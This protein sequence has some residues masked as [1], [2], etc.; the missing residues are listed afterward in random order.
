[1][2]RGIGG[3]TTKA[4]EVII[5]AVEFPEVR[6]GTVGTWVVSEILE[7]SSDL[8]SGVGEFCWCT[9]LLFNKVKEVTGSIFQVQDSL[10]GL[11]PL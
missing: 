11:V 8:V 6:F 9:D 7:F 10:S 3:G 2:G 5:Q 4:F 1:M